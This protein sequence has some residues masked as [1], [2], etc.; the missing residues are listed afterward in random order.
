MHGAMPGE[1]S[2]PLG[3][4]NG[5]NLAQWTEISQSPLTMKLPLLSPLILPASGRAWRKAQWVGRGPR[6]QHALLGALLSESGNSARP[7]PAGDRDLI[8]TT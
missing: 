8:T 5:Y 1:T 4:R 6:E 7:M 2:A 3:E